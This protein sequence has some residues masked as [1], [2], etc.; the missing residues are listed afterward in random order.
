MSYAEDRIKLQDVMLRYAAGVDDRDL[1]LYESCFADDV[2][3]VGFG[4]ETVIGAKSWRAFVEQALSKYGA[5]QHMLGPQLATI[6]G[7]LAHCRTDVQALHY[8]LD[9]EGATLTL[10]ATY[11]TDMRRFGEDWKIVRHQ[12]VARGTK[13]DGVG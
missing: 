9:T 2:E 8:L 11:F 13:L 6:D 5:T 10:W 12:L 4:E 1:D 7:D 3:V